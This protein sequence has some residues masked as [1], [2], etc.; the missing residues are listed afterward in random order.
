MVTKKYELMFILAPDLNE[1]AQKGFIDRIQ[2]YLA[3]AEATV[4]NFKLWGFR[5][6]AYTI[7]GHKE[8]RYYVT[9]FAMDTQKLAP[10]EHSLR[11]LS[12]GIL[13]ELI[14]CLPDNFVPEAVV[15]EAPPVSSATVPAPSVILTESADEFVD[16]REFDD[17]EE[18][19]DE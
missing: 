2:G 3:E 9:Q 17:E 16:E 10:F 1:E 15:T 12:E 5:R 11:M 14:T 18:P 6:M 13:R 4:Y 8:G 7:H 19:L